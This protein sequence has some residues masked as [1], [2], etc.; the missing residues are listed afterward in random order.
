VDTIDTS[1]EITSDVGEVNQISAEFGAGSQGRFSR[2]FVA[3]PMGARAAG[4]STFIDNGAAT[5][6]RE[7]GLVVHTTASVNLVL[8]LQHSSASGGTYVDLPG[9]LTFT[10]GRGSKRLVVPAQAIDRYTRV[11]WTGT[12]T[13]IAIIER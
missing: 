5:T 10:A 7:A 2:G 1:Y 9:T 4:N 6:G 13:F 11:L 12:G 8:K 3:S